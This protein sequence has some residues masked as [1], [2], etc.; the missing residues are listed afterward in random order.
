LESH[1]ATAQDRTA[2]RVYIALPLAIATL[3]LF[4]LLS[5]LIGLIQTP[6][7]MQVLTATGTSSTFA[8]FAV[9]GGG[10]TDIFLGGAILIRRHT[11]KAA[12]GMI[13]LST[14]YLLGA[15]LM[16]PALYADPLGPMVKVLPGMT[17]AALVALLMDDR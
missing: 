8:T 11:R 9:T 5:G 6:A 10:I 12:I 3:S 2:A 15:V 16:T 17:L 1:P 14:A 7:A 4:W 13:C